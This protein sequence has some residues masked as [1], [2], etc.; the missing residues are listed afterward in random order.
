MNFDVG[1]VPSVEGD[2]ADLWVHAPDRSEVTD[3]ADAID[4]ILARNPL[5]AG[6]A[7]EGNR[8]ILFVPPLAVYYDV[9]LDDRKVTV[10]AVWRWPESE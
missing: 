2:L 9:N 5:S 3:A 1:W 8:R 10:T 4:R 6:E 7:R